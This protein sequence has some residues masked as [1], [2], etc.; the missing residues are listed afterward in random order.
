[1]SVIKSTFNTNLASNSGSTFDN[2]AIL[3]LTNTTQSS[4]FN[5]GALVVSGGVGIAQNLNV[6]GTIINT[7]GISGGGTIS[8]S[9]LF[10][11]NQSY[12]TMISTVYNTTLTLPITTGMVYFVN[13]GTASAVTNLLITNLPVTAS[14]TPVS[15]VFNIIYITSGANYYTSGANTLSITMVNAYNSSITPLIGGGSVTLPTTYTHI[16]QTVTL[17][18]KTGGSTPTFVAFNNVQ[19]F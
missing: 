7:G 15:Y 10:N 8:T 1:M 14:G 4:A 5:S 17:I 13:S 2:T 6:G 12:D 18:N 3:S 9:G 16:M 11:A 19:G